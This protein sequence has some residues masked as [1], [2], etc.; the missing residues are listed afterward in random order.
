MQRAWM[1][2][3]QLQ[4]SVS[5]CE[6]NEVESTLIKDAD[7]TARLTWVERNR[8]CAHRARPKNLTIGNSRVQANREDWRREVASIIQTADCRGADRSR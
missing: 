4:Y 3:V 8:T 1:V 5:H 6:G 2:G 7:T